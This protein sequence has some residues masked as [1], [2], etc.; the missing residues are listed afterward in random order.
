MGYRAKADSTLS[1]APNA[2]SHYGALVLEDEQEKQVRGTSR[3]LLAA[4][5]VVV[6]TLG[7]FALSPSV[8]PQSTATV[9]VVNAVRARPMKAQDCACS[10][11]C[12]VALTADANGYM[13]HYCDITDP[14]DG[15]TCVGIDDMFYTETVGYVDGADCATA[16]N[17]RAA[18]DYVTGRYDCWSHPCETHGFCVDGVDTYTCLCEFGYEGPNCAQDIDECTLVDS[19]SDSDGAMDSFAVCDENAACTNSIGQY[20]CVCNAGWEGD[21]YV[22]NGVL[23]YNYPSW[24]TARSTAD[25]DYVQACQDIDDC[26]GN[27]CHNGGTCINL[28]G[29]PNNPPD[30]YGYDCECAVGPTGA[31]A[32]IGHDCEIDVDECDAAAP[33][34]DCDTNA[35][36][37]NLDGAFSCHCRAHWTPV[38]PT[39]SSPTYS[40]G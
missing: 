35:D 12:D 19:D 2:A 23:S 39:A 11:T 18:C 3:V 29:I 5:I 34:H 10:S 38:G 24:I 28:E 13:L 16:G 30:V 7:F 9:G 37:N 36:C 25:A 20:E 6:A 22:E 40:S 17:C 33:Q 14:G 21:G 27:P 26:R 1:M 15:E 4:G 32:W 31:K 8:Q